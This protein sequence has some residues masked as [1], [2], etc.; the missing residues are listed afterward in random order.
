MWIRTDDRL[1]SCSLL[2]CYVDWKEII[3][4]FRDKF[5]VIC[6]LEHMIENDVMT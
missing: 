6:G 3:G 5:E 4:N 2:K 1:L